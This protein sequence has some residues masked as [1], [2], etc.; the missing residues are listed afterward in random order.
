MKIHVVN[1]GETLHAIG[2]L[3]GIAPGLIARY[4][5]L[6]EPYRL[7]VGQ[8]L[9]IL[10]EAISVIISKR[11]LLNLMSSPKLPLSRSAKNL[12]HLT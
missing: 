11:L 4:N 6:R 9:L 1:S 10:Q 7:A 2:R 3:Y 5:G 8:S 12:P